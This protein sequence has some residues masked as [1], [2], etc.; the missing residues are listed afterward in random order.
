MLVCC[1]AAGLW[2]QYPPGT[3]WRRIRTEHFDVVYP[4]D[5]EAG[6]Q[7]AANALETMYAPLSRTL[8]AALPSHTTVV[9]ANQNV[10]RFS[11]GSV[12]LFPRMATFETMPQQTFWGTNDWLHR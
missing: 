1:L 11:G 4:S 9:L 12:S 7:R 2:A 8:G 6:A 10:T 5:I 3:E